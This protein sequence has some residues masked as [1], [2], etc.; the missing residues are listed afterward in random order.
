MSA[1]SSRI[2]NTK[3]NTVWAMVYKVLSIMLPFLTRTVLIYV[4]GIQYVGINGLVSSILQ[5]LS[6]AD[7][8]FSSAIIYSMYKPIAN[9][10]TDTINALLAFYAKIYR[11]IGLVILGIGLA[12]VPFL[13]KL[14]SGDC[15]NDVSIVI[16]YLIYLVNTSISYFLFAYKKS[17]LTA[18]Q[19]NDII[20]KVGAINKIATTVLQ[21]GGLYLISQYYAYIIVLPLIT[22]LD[23]LLCAWIS[24]KYYPQFKCSGELDKTVKADIVEKTKGLLVHKICGVTRNSCDNIFISMFLGLTPVGIYSNYYYIMTSIRGM[25]D[26]FT[27]SMSASVGN[28]VATETIDKNYLNLNQFTFIFEWIC[29]WCTICLLCLYQP[30]MELWVGKGAMFSFEVVIAISVYFYVWT[31]GDIKSQYADAAGLWWKDRFRA[32]AE[33]AGNILLNY[34]LVQKMGI[35]GIVIATAISIL[36]IGFPWGV[37]IVFD[38]Y[39]VT[40]SAVKYILSHII[41]AGVTLGISIITLLTTLQIPITGFAGLFV[42]AL[43]CLVLPNI[44]Y[45]AIYC[46]TPIF[47]ESMRFVKKV[48]VR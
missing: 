37:K 5:V 27:T 9:S 40:K 34:F 15:P 42:K 35:F 14:I 21:I 1:K 13:D 16:V 25:L 23:N 36:F 8:G 32:V 33:A 39:F 30:F 41:Y 12:L 29:G 17:L 26:V 18:L 20:S 7:L 31:M 47:K 45:L 24:H 4:L 46:K 6:L 38:G 43:V 3:R 11:I 19:R 28:S 44:L 10:D 48:V 2:A 22:L